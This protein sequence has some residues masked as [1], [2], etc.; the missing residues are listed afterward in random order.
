MGQC[1]SRQEES[2]LV[3]SLRAEIEALKAAQ[4][5]THARVK[6]LT[7]QLS[8]HKPGI[9]VT[10]S[11][12]T[13]AAIFDSDAV[14][15]AWQAQLDAEVDTMASLLDRAACTIA[16]GY[17]G[18]QA[19]QR[20]VQVRREH[21]EQRQHAEP[22]H[23][24]QQHEQHTHRYDDVVDDD[25]GEAPDE[26]GSAPATPT[27][28]GG[29]LGVSPTPLSPEA[30]VSSSQAQCNDSGSWPAACIPPAR[31]TQTTTS[32]RSALLEAAATPLPIT[33]RETD[34]QPAAPKPM[35]S[36]AAMAPRGY[37]SAAN[38]S[39]ADIATAATPADESPLA[40]GDATGSTPGRAKDE[41]EEHS[42]TERARGLRAVTAPQPKSSTP[43]NELVKPDV[44]L[45]HLLRSRREADPM[46]PESDDD[47]G[48][49]PASDD[50]G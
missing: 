37:P 36:R 10:G 47:D 13:T 20:A 3:A 7:Q 2:A 5:A 42:G 39:R 12:G 26:D 17:R 21:E 16:A 9:S 25:E 14:D 49:P 23:E 28:L 50:E 31:A 32:A 43:K 38:G 22:A 33:P 29:E 46:T 11:G 19:R 15:E 1:L 4:H 27:T 35:P 34:P 40:A 41:V 24:Q 30:P 44:H 18:S 6:L 48:L 45:G 8:A